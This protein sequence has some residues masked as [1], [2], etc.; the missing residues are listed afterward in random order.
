[1]SSVQFPSPGSAHPK[2]GIVAIH[3]GQG[4]PRVLHGLGLGAVMPR[5]SG[6]Q[7]VESKRDCRISSQ[8][9]NSSQ[10]LERGGFSALV[11]SSSIIV[12]A[13]G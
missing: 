10:G 5:A 13:N 9:M 11:C 4:I 7:N 2:G 12:S 1:M 3:L 6:L 8:S